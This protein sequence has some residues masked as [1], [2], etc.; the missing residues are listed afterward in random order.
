[1]SSVMRWD[2]F[3]DLTPLHDVMSQLVNQAVLRPGWLS[4]GQSWSGGAGGL[5]NVIELD[6]HYYCQVLLPGA[7]PEMVEL[8]VR[9]NNLT[10]KATI[11]EPFS[12]E[13]R[14]NA[15]YLLREFGPRELSRSIAFPKDVDAEHVDARFSNG[16][17]SIAIPI[18]QHAQPRRIAI[19]GDEPAQ[20][21]QGGQSEQSART[22]ESQSKS[23]SETFAGAGR[24]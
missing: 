10:L 11:T 12:D 13:Q 17:L 18:A 6:N 24:S 23:S 22:I 15:V 1:M 5:M 19:A 8:T 7:T 16:V 4:G 9:Q 20:V 21:T 2:P 14:K 3:G